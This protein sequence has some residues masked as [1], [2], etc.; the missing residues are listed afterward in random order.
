M[1]TK[2][3][4][5]ALCAFSGWK[6]RKKCQFNI[7]TYLYLCFF[8]NPCSSLM[9]CPGGHLSAAEHLLKIL[10]DFIF[11]PEIKSLHPFPSLHVT[12]CRCAPLGGRRPRQSLPGREGGHGPAGRLLGDTELRPRPLASAAAHGQLMTTS[13]LSQRK[14]ATSG[15]RP[16][17][18]K[19]GY[20]R[21]E[22]AFLISTG[23]GLF[24]IQTMISDLTLGYFE[25]M[26]HNPVSLHLI[27]Q[28]CSGNRI[29]ILVI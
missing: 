11:F 8:C 21:P 10:Y 13:R 22:A 28:C 29:G 19:H 6:K 9:E 23:W 17:F 12:N 5:R 26:K 4:E 18:S 7:F 20:T 3:A 25:I 24:S 1:C 2:Y 16:S 14:Q 27:F 15:P